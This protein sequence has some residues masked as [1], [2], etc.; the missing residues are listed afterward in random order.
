MTANHIFIAVL[1]L[2]C[3]SSLPATAKTIQ[4]DAKREPG[5]EWTSYET[6]TV[7]L[8]RNYRRKSIKTNAYG[9]RMDRRERGTG[10]FRTIEKNGR[11]WLVDPEGYLNIN[12]GVV[13]VKPGAGP[14]QKKAFKR[15]FKSTAAWAEETVEFLREHGFSGTGAWS[16]D[17]LLSGVPD[18]ISYCVNW[19]FMSSFA[20][21]R[22]RQGSGHVEFPGHCIP[23]FDPEW[24]EF[25]ESH[26][27]RKM[28]EYKDDP[29]LLGHFFDNELPLKPRMLERYLTLPEDDHGHKAAREFIES[30]FGKGTSV[31][32]LKEDD[33]QAFDDL[34]MEKYMGTIAR[35]IRKVDP[36]HMLLGPRLYSKNASGAII[37]KYVDAFSYNLYGKWSPDW[38][39]MD[40]Y[41]AIGKPLLVTEYYVKGMDIP[42]LTNESGAGWCV[43]TQKDRGLFYQS[44]GLDLL[45]TKC[46]IGWQWF[47]YQDNDPGNTRTDPSNRNSNKGIV[48][49]EYNGYEPL[50][51]EMKK[52]NTQIY[53]V[54][55]HFDG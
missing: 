45:E 24:K 39:A 8:L 7:D 46:C 12:R 33:W 9:S 41:S 14:A 20:R 27:L 44:F 29:Y 40:L 18:R 13:S 53:S 23:V 35:A 47:K 50:L 19:K 25:C 55:D 22:T 52:M 30:R 31:K 15:E 54:I 36:N 10:F 49:C 16:D 21:G 26:A 42:G 37:G 2:L 32:K 4:V 5:M 28:A 1:A 3:T 11:W 34:V 43:P 38:K 48:S 17:E 51:R 6:R